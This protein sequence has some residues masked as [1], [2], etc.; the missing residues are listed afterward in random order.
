MS[1]TR[2]RERRKQR[3]QDKGRQRKLTIA[4]IIGIVAVLALVIV[5]VSSLPADAA[6][7]EGI[8][9]Q[10]AGLPQSVNED[11][12]PVLGN[13]DAP[14]S[15]VEVSSFDCPSCGLFYK[16][17]AGEL[18]D[19]VRDGEISFTY[20]PVYGTGGM[21]NGQGAAR[22][23]VC[24]GEQDSFWTYHAMLFSWQDTY[25]NAA[26]S[27]SRLA[28]G[29]DA[30]ELDRAAWDACINSSRPDSL[31]EEAISYVNTLGERF[32]GTPTILVNGERVEPTS[33]MVHSAIDSALATSGIAPVPVGEESEIEAEATEEAVVDVEAE[34][35]AEAEEEP[36]SETEETE[37][38]VE[39]EATAEATEEAGE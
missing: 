27:G 12:F 1:R 13:P 29:A 11:G 36:T 25:G 17:V 24:A 9:A 16:N 38:E 37:A 5:V 22:A 23:A 30:L 34:A 39:A 28:S 14:V 7:P 31:L 20:V 4:A 6:L 8:E 19:R 15:V 2:T 26:F 10:Y 32:Q 35:T 18:V 3:E 33:G 21:P